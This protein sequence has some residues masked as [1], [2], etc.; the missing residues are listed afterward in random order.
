VRYS[1]DKKRMTIE[2]EL[3]ASAF[4]AATMDTQQPSDRPPPRPPTG[5]LLN[6]DVVATRPANDAPGTTAAT[7]EA[8]GF[9][10][11]GTAVTS[12]LA[13]DDGM[14]RKFER[15]DTYW[16]YDMPASMQTLVA[17][18]TVGVGGGWSRPVRYAGVRWGRDFGLRPGFV[19]MPLRSIAGQAALPSTVDV[20]VNDSRRFSESVRPGPF[21]ITNVPVITGAGEVNLVVR[22]LLGRQTVITQS[23]YASPRLL[24]KGLTD[25]SFESGRLRIGFGDDSQYRDPFGAVTLRRGLTAGLTAEARIEAQPERQASGFEFASLLGTWGVGRVAVAGSR[26]QLHGFSEQGAIVRA[27]IERSTPVGGGALQYEYATRGFA[28]FGEISGPMGITSRSREQLLASIGGRLWG[29][30]NGGVSYAR[31]TLWDG[32]RDSTLGLSLSVPV[33]SRASL[34]LAAARRLDNRRSW[35]GSIN[36]NVPFGEGIYAGARV[37]HQD[38]GTSRATAL[39]VRNPPAGPGLGWRTEVSTDER[40]RARAGL[41]YNTNHGDLTADAVADAEARVSSRIGARGTLGLMA[42]VP[43]AS[44]PV[45]QGSFAVVKVEGVPGVPIKR[46]NQVVGQT[47]E[48]GLAFVP[49]LVPWHRNRIEIAPEDLPLDADV[50]A[51]AQEVVP[52]ARSGSFVSFDVRRTRQALLVLRQADGQPVPVGARVQLLPAGPEFQA[53]RRGEVWLTDLAGDK[54]HL[55]VTWDRRG[56]EL[57][58][59]VPAT[60]NGAPVTLEPLVCDGGSP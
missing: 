37:E 14:Q 23:Y 44:R 41:Q 5:A 28:P 6:Y 9:G 26:D 16:Q 45:G 39:A 42:G 3:P 51:V 1:V 52:Y 19:T 46:S 34:T 13:S 10:P 49:G 56:C 4:A 8:V 48:R 17:G 38:D 58:V 29:A 18:D 27:G 2:V 50:G 55:K 54:Q 36:L 35:S 22:D 20:L 33:G 31:R 43:F 11:F 60:E 47:D 25:F 7:L 24:A 32:T 40:Q 53:G 57:D 12:G 59:L 21:D 30:M 15:L